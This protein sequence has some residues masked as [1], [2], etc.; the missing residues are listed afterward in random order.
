[1]KDF[2]IISYNILNDVF[3]TK[4]WAEESIEDNLQE[5]D[6]SHADIKKVYE[7]IYGILRNK[8]F[9]DFH[10]GRFIKKPVKD[11][12]LFNI[13]RIGYY[14]LKYMKS[15]P[16]YAAINVCVELAKTSVHPG[17]SGFVNAV[18]RNV[19]R[20]RETNVK[21]PDGDRVEHLSIKYSYEP[22][23]VGFLQ[24]N[25][26]DEMENI[27][28]AGN[29]KPPLFLKVNDLKTNAE[30]LINE[31]KKR[32][33]E[34][35]R[36]HKINGALLVKK[37]NALNTE[38]FEKGYFYV[39]DVSSQCM[40]LLVE[41][42]KDEAIIDVGSAP[43]GKCAFFSISMKN[44]GQIVSIESKK[45]RIKMMERNFL[46]LG[47][48]NVR[49]LEHDATVDIPEFHDKADKIVFDAPCSAMGVI[50]RHPEKK[51]C[52]NEKELKEF[53]ELQAKILNT[54]KNW[55]KKGGFIFYSTCTLNPGENENL[56]EKF[57]KKN[58]NF[59]IEDI[60]EIAAFK[61]TQFKRG[62]F[63]QSL[64]GND[65]NM[66]GFFIAKLKRIK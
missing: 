14:Q 3:I 64:P 9:I 59:K 24:K 7:L 35:E 5:I 27:M 20:S 60:K 44:N 65:L 26:P 37:G 53:P 40:G 58:E 34:S 62:R 18:L 54:V 47:I 66:D 25:Y 1:M 48:N 11:V 10:L 30:E 43:G 39:Q 6:S 8:N 29:E 22:W 42:K 33:I 49:I 15:I 46:R 57:L 41:A 45:E 13:L 50:R 16:P 55:V 21:I 31:L 17:V 52:L 56:I 19:S 61:L 51:W 32:G 28:K 38:L 4:R 23:M 63:F 12:K 36:V 2:R